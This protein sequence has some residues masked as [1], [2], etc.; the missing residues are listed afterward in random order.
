[1]KLILVWIKEKPQAV[2]YDEYMDEFG[3]HVRWYPIEG[4]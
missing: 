4:K 1:M 2:D 3:Q